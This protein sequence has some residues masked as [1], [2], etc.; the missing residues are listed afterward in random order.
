MFERA[1]RV[2]KL[3]VWGVKFTF[4]MIR[5]Y[6]NAQKKKLEGKKFQ[7]PESKDNA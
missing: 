3:I 2:L 7:N 4:A 5:R 1:K 6:E